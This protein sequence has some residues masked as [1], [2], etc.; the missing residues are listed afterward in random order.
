MQLPDAFSSATHLVRLGYISK[1]RI[2]HANKHAIPLWMAGILNNR[3]DV[4]APLRHVD[5]VSAT[6]VG[7]FNSIDNALL[8]QCQK[9]CLATKFK[10]SLCSHRA[11]QIP[12]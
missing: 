2:D 5:K 12:I 4:G 11:G 1:D 9:V 3:N 10:G 7:E 8:Q 6:A